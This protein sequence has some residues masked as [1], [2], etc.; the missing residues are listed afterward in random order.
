MAEYALFI[1]WNRS[2][3]GR[4][5]QA[6]ELFLRVV[7]HPFGYIKKNI[8]F[9]Q[10]SLRGRQGA[11]AEASIVATCFNLTRMISLLGGVQMFVAKLSTA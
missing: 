1:G 8:A 6:M 2:V 3:A 7:E 10:F 4:E 11:Q 9:R 5:Q